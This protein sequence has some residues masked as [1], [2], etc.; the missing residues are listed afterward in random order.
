MYH[1]LPTDIQREIYNLLKNYWDRKKLSPKFLNNPD[2][3]YWKVKVSTLT[4]ETT[5]EWIS[6]R[7]FYESL[8]C[9]EIYKG[10]HSKLLQ[11]MVEDEWFLTKH[12]NLKDKDGGTALMRGVFLNEEIVKI[13][14]DAGA[15]LNVQDSFGLTALMNSV[16]I[17]SIKN[18]KHLLDAGANVNLQDN[19]GKTA[20]IFE[21]DN[22]KG[23]NIRY[24]LAAG[25]NVNHRDCWGQ[26][27]LI[28]GIGSLDI[29][30]YKLLIDA[31]ADVNL[32]NGI[33]WTPLF[34]A[35]INSGIEIVKLL[36]A[37]GANV[38][39]QNKEGQTALSLAMDKR[40][41]EIIQLLLDAGAKKI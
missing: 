11:K 40:H 28:R 26:T 2:D 30:N 41:E 38:N 36:L 39:Y 35:V 12:V 16:R 23:E 27:A 25:A 13:L 6:Y 37:A 29:E 24:L 31:G 15:D 7:A 18:I 3:Y 1:S 32:Q 14:I 17:I 4:D 19:D 20:L 34:K 22:T 5:P 33:G 8:L 21:A 10:W 9:R